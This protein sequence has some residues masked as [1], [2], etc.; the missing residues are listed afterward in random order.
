MNV[1]EQDQLSPEELS[2]LLRAA[3]EPVRP[4]AEGYQRIRAGV[5]RR[6]R[7]RIPLLAAGG[8]A[9]AG[10][11][12]LAVLLLRPEPKSVVVEPPP[13]LNVTGQTAQGSST[14][15]GSTDPNG[16]SHGPSSPGSTPPVGGTST[17]AV[18]GSPTGPTSPGVRTSDAGSQTRPPA[19]GRPAR[20]GD[21]DGDGMADEVSVSGPTVEVRMSR[22]ET[23]RYD[24][25]AG[26]ALGSPAGFDLDGDGYSELIVRT[27]PAGGLADYAVLRFVSP[28]VVAMVPDLP[29]ARL[30]AGAS[31]GQTAAGFRCSHDG[32]TVVAGVAVDGGQSYTVTTTTLRLAFDRWEAVGTPTSATMPA[33]EATPL[34]TADC[35]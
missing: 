9:M 20:D 18:S 8:V 15:A 34:F 35:G 21:I 26:S 29:S 4:S 17:P 24:F 2:R 16:S 10:L 7:W 19:S 23:A 22:G 27:G 28:G 5:E 25:P 13:G 6:N 14:G 32:V 3:V 11:I 31:S 30:A 1:P 33:A 12:G